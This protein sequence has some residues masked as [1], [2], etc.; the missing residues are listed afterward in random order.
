MKI[1][2][3]GRVLAIRGEWPIPKVAK[4]KEG[5]N[6]EKPKPDKEKKKGKDSANQTVVSVEPKGE[7]EFVV[8]TVRQTP[9]RWADCGSRC[10]RQATKS[11]SFVA[12]ASILRSQWV[13]NIQHA[14]DHTTP[15][16]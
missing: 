1:Q 3:G 7:K 13:S 4:G 15:S 2:K 16:A 8:L 14:L 5:L 10:T 9:L 11:L 6:N 12:D